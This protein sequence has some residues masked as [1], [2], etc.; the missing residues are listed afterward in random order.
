LRPSQART[1]V[2]PEDPLL[3]DRVKATEDAYA[4]TKLAGICR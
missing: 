2:D 4:I 1:A 3:T